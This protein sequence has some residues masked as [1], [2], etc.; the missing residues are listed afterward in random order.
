LGILNF[1][2]FYSIVFNVQLTDYDIE[3]IQKAKDI[4]VADL[5]IHHKIELIARMVNLGTSKLKISF[6]LYYG[7]GLYTFLKRQRMIKA[8]E[9]LIGTDKTIKQIT[10]SIGFKHTSN[11]TKAFGSYH[12]IT[13]GKY[14]K[15]F[16]RK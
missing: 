6:K 7:L 1:S 4:I 15:Y 13:P 8:A 14:R 11:F 16:S 2:R 12:G 10:K 9:L 3:C 5:S